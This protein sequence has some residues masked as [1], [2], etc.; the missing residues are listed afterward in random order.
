MFVLCKDK[1]ILDFRTHVRTQRYRDQDFHKRQTGCL[2]SDIFVKV[3]SLS[4]NLP[5]CSD[6]CYFF[7]NVQYFQHKWC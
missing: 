6:K 7:E 5:V 2:L 4:Y 1:H 3:D